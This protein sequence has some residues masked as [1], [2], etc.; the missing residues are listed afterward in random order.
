MQKTT[1]YEQQEDY[2]YA[3]EV[4]EFYIVKTELTKN[5]THQS[6]KWKEIAIGKTREA[7][8]K[9]MVGRN[10]RNMRIVKR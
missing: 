6:Y 4:K 2:E 5:R 10:V 8:E 3:L 7:L 1:T 9:L